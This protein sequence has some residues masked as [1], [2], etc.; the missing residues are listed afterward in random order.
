MRGMFQ[1][2]CENCGAES[3]EDADLSTDEII[4]KWNTRPIEDALSARIAELEKM[5]ADGR[6]IN[7]EYVHSVEWKLAKERGHTAEL[8]E[9]NRWIPVSEKLPEGD[10]PVLVLDATVTPPN[11]AIAKHSNWNYYVANKYLTIT[12]WAAMPPLP[13]K[14]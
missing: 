3:R 10:M 5:L 2:W 7:L 4:Q 8:M 12:H 14:E 13:E 11:F 1:V 6:S 9:K